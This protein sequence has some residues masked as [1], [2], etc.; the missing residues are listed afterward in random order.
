MSKFNFDFKS[1]IKPYGAE[2]FKT[3]EHYNLP[4]VN[5]EHTGGKFDMPIMKVCKHVPKSLIP[6]N[7][8][9]SS[10]DYS[11]GIHFFIDDYQF[12]RL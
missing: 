1:K 6:F 9:M 12:E 4:I 11:A 10:N 8:A 3:D 7:Y 5:T 2:R